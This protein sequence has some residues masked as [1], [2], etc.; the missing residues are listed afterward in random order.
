MRLL[1]LT[2]QLGAWSTWGKHRAPNIQH[3]QLAA[4]LREKGA[5]EVMALDC[6]ALEINE[7]EMMEEIKKIRPEA[8][9]V[10]ELLHTTGGAAVIHYFNKAVK[11]VKE[12]LPSTITIAG[13]I[14]YSGL[15]KESLAA[16]PAIDYLIISEGEYT[17]WELVEELKTGN[18]CLSEIDGL[19]YRKDG[20]IIINRPRNLIENLDELPMPAYDLF[21]MDRYVGHTY[22]K[23]YVEPVTSRGCKGGCNFCYTWS[24]YDTRRPKDFLNYRFRSGK[25]VA[26]ELEKLKKEFGVRVAIF[27][28]DD[29]NENRERVVEM[30]EELIRRNVDI[31]WMILGRANNYVRDI[32]IF[33]LMRKAGCYMALVGIEAATDLE[34]RGIGKGITLQQVRDAIKALR[35]ADIASV[36]TYMMGFWEDD[37]ATIKK[38]AAFIDE[39]DP[40]IAAIQIMTP[41]PGSPLW[42]RYIK[43][44]LIN[45]DKIMDEIRY[46]D[47]HH[48]VVPTKHLSLEDISRLANWAYRE[49]FSK[50]GRLQRAL[51]YYTSPYVALCVRDYMNNATRF[52][53]ALKGEDF[54]V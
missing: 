19:G 8:V 45:P 50:P 4:F 33:P 9:Y 36:G 11:R 53:K 38:R 7:D 25:K 20:E 52:E 54:F 51:S 18:P 12:E 22:L 49:F 40:D 2:P 32:D 39:V 21:P 10:G 23:P 5:A 46:W 26:D 42:D 17:L 1:F 6:R 37:E 35:E 16:N 41:M 15:P 24:V 27:L 14:F 3:A 34:L 48:P 44:G 29:F 30:C 31:S 28:E 43:L 47:F 13:G